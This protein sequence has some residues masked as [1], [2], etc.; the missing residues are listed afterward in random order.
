MFARKNIFAIVFLLFVSCFLYLGVFLAHAD[1][2]SDLQDQI[3]ALNKARELSVNA[4]KPLEGQVESLQRQ[5]AQIQAI[6]NNL[7]AG[8]KQKQ[9][10]LDVREEKLAL[11]QA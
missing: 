5:L 2:I 8:I 6:L 1:E 10:D 9:A 7:S 11:Q 3:N 4:T